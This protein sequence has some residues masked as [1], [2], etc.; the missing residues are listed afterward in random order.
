MRRVCCA[1]AIALAAASDPLASV[2]QSC[3]FAL[4]HGLTADGSGSP[5]LRLAYDNGTKILKASRRAASESPF[6]DARRGVPQL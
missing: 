4:R 3:R 1:A 2:D 5:A 6:L